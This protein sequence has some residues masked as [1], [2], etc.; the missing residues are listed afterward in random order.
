MRTAFTVLAVLVVTSAVQADV[1]RP[2]RSILTRSEHAHAHAL[3]PGA[4]DLVRGA[5]YGYDVTHVDLDMTVDFDTNTID[6]TSTLSVTVTEEG[7]AT[8]TVDLNDA[9]TVSG[10]TVDDGSRFFTQNAETVDV[11]LGGAQSAG[12]MLD[13]AVSYNGTPSIVGNKSMRFRT[14]DGTE[15]VYALSTPFSNPTTT[16][17]PISHYWRA[18]KDDPTDKST[19]S[20]AITVPDDMRACTNGALTAEV[21]NGDGTITYHWAHSYPVAPYLITMGA[22]NY[23]VY[24]DTY[25]STSG[26]MPVQNYLFPSDTTMVATDWANT[27][28]HLETLSSIFGE[29]PFFNDKYGM[30]EILPGPAIEHQTMVTIPRNII[31]GLLTYEWIYVHEM[32]HAWFGDHVTVADWDHVWLAEGFASYTE[33]LYYEAVEGGSALVDYMLNLDDGPYAGTVVPP[34]YV[35]DSIVYDKGAWVAHMLRHILGDGPFFAFLQDYL[36]THNADPKPFVWTKK[37][38]VILAKTKRARTALDAVKAG[39]QALESDH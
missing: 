20:A 38:D 17:I 30:Y 27:V 4:L 19:Y 22:T 13:V 5:D 33:A 28:L 6:C 36:D 3:P 31:D 9:L 29:Y 15:M 25:V 23:V 26:S 10:V 37:A 11:N 24:E 2:D 32:G 16:V 8:L 18:C 14:W 39:N 34:S 35:W 7:L 21:D 1:P 12:T